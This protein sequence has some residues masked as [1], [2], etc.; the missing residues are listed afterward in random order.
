MQPVILKIYRKSTRGV[1]SIEEWPKP[2][3]VFISQV[4]QRK[5]ERLSILKAEEQP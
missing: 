3:F 1:L 4:N 2:F 5:K